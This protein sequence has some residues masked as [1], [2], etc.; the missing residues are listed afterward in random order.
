MGNDD[1]VMLKRR[2]PKL[3]PKLV[4]NTCL[5]LKSRELLL[6]L[7][8]GE[9]VFLQRKKPICLSKRFVY[10]ISSFEHIFKCRSVLSIESTE[11]EPKKHLIG[12]FWHLGTDECRMMLVQ[13][14]RFGDSSRM[15][16]I[17]KEAGEPVSETS[18][19]LQSELWDVL[20]NGCKDAL[21]RA[22]ADSK[23]YIVVSL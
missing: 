5:H 22:G 15:K 18:T 6:V 17:A 13:V 4:K 7:L 19:S 3:E 14:K 8:S 10:E 23:V 11:V 12:H 21:R 20:V 16:L 2:L 1:E 9:A